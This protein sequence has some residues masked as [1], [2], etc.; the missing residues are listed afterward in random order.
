M[1]KMGVKRDSKVKGGQAA[2]EASAAALEGG[3]KLS[4]Q[5]E[6]AA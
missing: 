6:G 4:I 3:Q 5:Y 1:D 2:A